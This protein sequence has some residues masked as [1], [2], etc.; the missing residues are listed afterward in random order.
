MKQKIN[1]LGSSSRIK[2]ILHELNDR[3][4]KLEQSPT[5]EDI[6]LPCPFCGS[7]DVQLHMN[8]F[9]YDYYYHCTNS[10]CL[11]SSGS[12]RTAQLALDAWNG[13]A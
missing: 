3:V 8:K 6:L 1:N 7:M 9:S 12:K 10:P 11:A 4:I 13:R 5:N 2:N